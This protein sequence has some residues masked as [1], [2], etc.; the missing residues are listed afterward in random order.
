MVEKGRKEGAEKHEIWELKLKPEAMVGKR[1][2]PITPPPTWKQLSPTAAPSTH[3]HQNHSNNNLSARK[4]CANLWEIQHQNHHPPQMNN[5]H[6]VATARI[7]QFRDDLVVDPLQQVADYYPPSTPASSVDS[8]GRLGESSQSLKTSTEFLKVLNRIWSLEEQHLSNVSLVKAL[9]I[10]RDTARSQIKQLLREQQADRDEID[11]LMKQVAEDKLFRKNKENDRIKVALQTVKDELEAERKLRRRSESLHRKLAREVSE[12]K[13]AFAKAL[14]E[15]ERER[16]ARTLL[17]ELCD[18]FAREIGDYEQEVRTMRH[19]DHSG[20]DGQD[21][22]IVHISE[23][24]LDERLQM[25]LAEKRCDVGEKNTIVDKLSFEIETFLKTK[26]SGEINSNTLSPMRDPKRNS[27][28]RRQSLE[29]YALHAAASAPQDI[30]DDGDSE[31]SDSHCFE[32]VNKAAGDK[33]TNSVSKP[34]RHELEDEAVEENDI[35]EVRKSNPVKKKPGTG[36]RIKGRNA[37]ISQIQFEEYMERAMSGNEKKTHLLNRD[38]KEEEDVHPENCEVTDGRR[39]KDE[40]H[41][42]NANNVIDDLIKRSRILLADNGRKEVYREDDIR[43]DSSAWRGVPS[44]VQQWVSKFATPDLEIS[45][46]S[47]QWAP[48]LKG[49]SLK[50][51]LMEARLEGQH[52]RL[53]GSKG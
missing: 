21:R 1:G 8:R 44:P 42:S 37:S 10:E 9:K 30:G 11:D 17:E 13:S 45:E 12:M 6:K 19:K 23:A 22:L 33:T 46:S 4:L 16:K 35:S 3:H 49:N 20:R 36:E 31:C 41:G 29:S 2:G 14:K 5:P 26:R 28:L 53:K 51:R 40:N 15:L 52:S 48:N 47:S 43:E 50:A 34:K 25:K 24:W 18:E 27:Y 32:L 38:E 7:H 39:R